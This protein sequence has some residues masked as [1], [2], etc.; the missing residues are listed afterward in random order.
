MSEPIQPSVPFIWPEPRVSARVVAPYASLPFDEVA[1][2]SI[3]VFGVASAINRKAVE[4]MVGYLADG[5]GQT[6]LRLVI[7]IQPTCRTTEADLL[8]LVRLA[9]R[10]KERA[11]FRVYPSRCATARRTSFASRRSMPAL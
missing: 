4:W 3:S 5:E 6:R 8:E 2:S 11:A 10:Y 7:S 9:E 1:R